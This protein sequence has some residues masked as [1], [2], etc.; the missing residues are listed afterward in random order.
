M[1]KNKNIRKIAKNVLP[2]HLNKFVSFVCVNLEK[3]AVI[4][5][6]RT[7]INVFYNNE[8][9]ITNQSAGKYQIKDFKK[10]MTK[11]HL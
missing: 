2:K 11:A 9:K 6:V 5:S 7:C 4:F 10:R 1:T 3:W 8:Q